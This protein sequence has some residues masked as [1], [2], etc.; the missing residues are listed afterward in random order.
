MT[1]EQKDE[2]KQLIKDAM[3]ECD[4]RVSCPMIPPYHEE[5]HE[6]FQKW[7]E[8]MANS[9]KT[10]WDMILKAVIAFII[11]IVAV[12]FYATIPRQ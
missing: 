7:I 1:D 3:S 8:F 4:V 11:G 5:H 6:L 9:R 12:G 2:F 10:A